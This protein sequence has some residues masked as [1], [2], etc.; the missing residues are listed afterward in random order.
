MSNVLAT[1]APTATR[2][3][4][5]SATSYEAAARPVDRLS[6]QGFPV[7]QCGSLAPGSAMSSR[8]RG[9]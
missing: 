7:E 5:T 4:I 2:R 3:T 6:D 8:S 9:A 1:V